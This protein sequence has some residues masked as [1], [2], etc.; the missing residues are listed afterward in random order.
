MYLQMWLRR[1]HP[2][3]IL[4]YTLYLTRCLSML[5]YLPHAHHLAKSLNP[6]ARKVS[7]I[8]I[9]T[10]NSLNPF[11]QHQISY[12]S[13]GSDQTPSS[14]DR[15]RQLEGVNIHSSSSPPS[16]STMFSSSLPPSTSPCLTSSTSRF[17]TISG[18]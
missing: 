7:T 5:C 10:T 17:T 6:Y 1:P 18:P 16:T 3:Q 11:T 12:K 4:I 2:R 8:S 15:R 14:L 13:P 9:R